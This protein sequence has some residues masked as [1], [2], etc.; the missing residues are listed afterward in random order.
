MSDGQDITPVGR[1]TPTEGTELTLMQ[2]LFG[3][4]GRLPGGIEAQDLPTGTQR[5]RP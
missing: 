1:E 2:Q 3:N 5:P 4:L